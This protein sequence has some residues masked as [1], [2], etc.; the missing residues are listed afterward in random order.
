[1]FALTVRFQLD[2]AHLYSGLTGLHCKA[3]VL[4]EAS[5]EYGGHYV[6]EN[7][8]ALDTFLESELFQGAVTKFGSP[9]VHVH[10]IV[11]YLER[12]A[13]VGHSCRLMPAIF[14]QACSRLEKCV[15]SERTPCRA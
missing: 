5:G 6:W 7:R 10:E 2:R 8:A 4:D 14:Q 13:V 15:R 3:F 12:G 11:A 1:M 9:Q